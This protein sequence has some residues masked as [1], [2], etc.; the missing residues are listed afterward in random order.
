MLLEI[1]KFIS[2]SIFIVLISKYVLVGNL[3]RLA[4]NLELK[5]KTIGTITGF[6]T[7]VPELLTVIVSC[8]RGFFN[9]SIYSILSSN[10]INLVQYLGSIILNKNIRKLKNNAIKTDIILSLFTIII[11]IAL[12]K[13]KMELNINIVPFFIILYIFFKFLNNNA[14]KLYLDNFNNGKLNM[15]IDINSNRNRKSKK[16]DLDKNIK[17]V[18]YSLILT[19]SGIIL[20]IIGNLLGN[21]V[22]NLCSIFNVPEIL[23]G[24]LLGFTTSIPELITFIESQ[25]RSIKNSNNI[26]GVIEATNNLLTSNTLNLFVIES[27]GIIMIWLI[28]IE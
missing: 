14:H 21:T 1:I 11:P 5:A 16:E 26:E 13:I 22:Q 3:R 2:Y 9:A 10:I 25:R 27:I 12:L 19:L 20:F 18:R 23:V 15:K 24:I 8:L 28:R 4:E 7:S 17:I 6:S